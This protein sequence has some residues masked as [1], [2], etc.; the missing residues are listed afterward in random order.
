RPLG[1][2]EQV[3][4]LPPGILAA[5][6]LDHAGEHRLF[7]FRTTHPEKLVARDRVP[8][9]WPTVNLLVV[10]DKPGA[11]D[12]MESL[13]D[14]LEANHRP[15]ARLS[16]LSWL[17]VSHGLGGRVP[18]RKVLLSLLAAENPPARQPA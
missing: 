10:F 3:A 14:F 18:L 15:A 2:A 11:I 12:R 17:R 8:G 6:L 13:F 16:V 9:V 4:L 1:R 7:V 5:Y